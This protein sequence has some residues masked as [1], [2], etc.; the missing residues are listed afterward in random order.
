MPKVGV[1][2][3][4]WGWVDFLLY[5]RAPAREAALPCMP[6][7]GDALYISIFQGL[8]LYCLNVGILLS[9]TRRI[10][11]RIPIPR[12]S[13]ANKCKT[14]RRIAR[15]LPLIHNF[16]PCFQGYPQLQAVAS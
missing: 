9:R 5:P 16:S 1:I 14:K 13:L 12:L 4:A 11:R 10:I 2:R 15:R 6:P 8:A 3:T 7:R